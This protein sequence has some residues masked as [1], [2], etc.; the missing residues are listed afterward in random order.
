[1]GKTLLRQ[2]IPKNNFKIMK[3]IKILFLSHIEDFSKSQIDVGRQCI[4]TLLDNNVLYLDY[5]EI[6]NKYGFSGVH[7]YIKEYVKNNGINSIIYGSSP[8]EFY[9][10][11]NYFEKLRKVIFL[12]MMTGDTE[13]YYKFAIN[14]TPRQWI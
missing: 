13:Y 12:V 7:N 6:Y 8:S 11:V 2:T 10:D 14:I 1:M 4:Q 9:F 5:I 3:K